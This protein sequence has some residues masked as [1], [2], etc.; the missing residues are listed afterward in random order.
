MAML[1][2]PN[3]ANLTGLL[4][5]LLRT[6]SCWFGGLTDAKNCGVR[7]ASGP[8]CPRTPVLRTSAVAV[9]TPRINFSFKGGQRSLGHLECS[10]CTLFHQRTL[11]CDYEIL[12]TIFSSNVIAHYVEDVSS[13]RKSR[14]G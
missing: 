14:C 5:G 6:T 12:Q 7:R 2:R 3:L 9:S 11:W 1:T 10:K 8:Y 13:V 4:T